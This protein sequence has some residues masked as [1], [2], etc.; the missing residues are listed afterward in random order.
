MPAATEAQT[1][2]TVNA[3]HRDT[4]IPCAASESHRSSLGLVLRMVAR[5]A[6]EFVREAACETPLELGAGEGFGVELELGRDRRSLAAVAAFLIMVTD[7]IARWQSGVCGTRKATCR[8]G[9]LST[10]EMQDTL[11]CTGQT[12][13]H[14]RVSHSQRPQG[15]HH[16]HTTPQHD[17]S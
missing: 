7:V 12:H 11:H 16:G 6:G 4:T 10:G 9:K 17:A 5:I 2:S 14:T 8:A 15:L 3:A 1:M 13:A